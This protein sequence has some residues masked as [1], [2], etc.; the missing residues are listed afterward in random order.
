MCQHADAPPSQAGSSCCESWFGRHMAISWT[1]GQTSSCR[2]LEY[3]FHECSQKPVI[4]WPLYCPSRFCCLPSSEP[5]MSRTL[6]TSTSR[7]RASLMY[8]QP[9][10]DSICKYVQ[11]A[12][13][14]WLYHTIWYVESAMPQGAMQVIF[15]CRRTKWI[16]HLLTVVQQQFVSASEGFAGTEASE[17]GVVRKISPVWRACRRSFQD[18]QALALL[19][20]NLLIPQLKRMTEFSSQRWF[21][22]Y[23]LYPFL[24]LSFWHPISALP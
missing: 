24:S 9:Q 22:A 11:K 17:W 12:V 6:M 16:S 10:R 5:S 1:G 21:P 13:P 2:M 23:N 7:R 3:G 18:L 15:E 8:S 14:S 19:G 20:R 4:I